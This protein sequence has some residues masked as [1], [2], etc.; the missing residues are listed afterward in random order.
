MNDGIE[1]IQSGRERLKSLE[2]ENRYVFHGSEN[3][4]IS[5]LEPRQAYTVVDGENLEDDKPAIH[6][7]PISE[8]AIFMA[9]VN[10]KNCPLGFNSGFEHR[11]SKTILHASKESLDQLNENSKGY[12]YVLPKEDFSPRGAVQSIS[13]KESSPLQI[14]E[15]TKSD[16]PKEIEVR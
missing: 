10:M 15:V 13:Y 2:L 16:L 9:I 11:N 7:S 8:I 5:V 12:V 4:N 6:A 1:K 14:V 3:P